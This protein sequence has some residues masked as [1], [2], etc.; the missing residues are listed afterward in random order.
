LKGTVIAMGARGLGHGI[1]MSLSDY[2][3]D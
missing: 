3:F 1:A 2:S